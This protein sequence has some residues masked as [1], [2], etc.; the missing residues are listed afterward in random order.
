MNMIIRYGLAL[1]VLVTAFVTNAL[2]EDP[3]A[4]WNRL[5]KKR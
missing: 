2:A 4:A 3:I 1:A 5:A